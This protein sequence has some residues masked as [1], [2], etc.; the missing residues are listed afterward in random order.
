MTDSTPTRRGPGQPPK[1]GA[2]MTVRQGVC[3]TEA[4]REEIAAAVPDGHPVGRWIVDAAI[5]RARRE[6][7]AAARRLGH[8]LGLPKK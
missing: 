3:M 2:P 4:E 5:E 7:R 6:A 1:Y 8:E